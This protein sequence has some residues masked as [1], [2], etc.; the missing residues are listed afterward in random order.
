VESLRTT[1]ED[2]DLRDPARPSPA[3]AGVVLCGGRSV[4][5]GVDKATIE[6][7]GTTL[8]ARALGRLTEVCDPVFVA[9]GGLHLGID[10]TLL[11][12]DALPDAGPL[13]GIVAALRRCRHPLLAV[14]A[15]DM[16]WIDPALL[17]LLADRIGDHDIALCLTQH[18]PEPLHAVYAQSALPVAEAVLHSPDR[19]VLGMIARLRALVVT[20]EEWRVAG[21][22]ERFASNVNTPADLAGVSPETRR[23][24][25]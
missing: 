1:G 24:A 9:P 5:M 21:V 2:V 13:G 23:P 19:S 18:G 3:L 17:R 12:P 10:A 15:V 8:L 25:T 11:V 22:A 4:R 14:V 6:I 16:P 20:E 7:G